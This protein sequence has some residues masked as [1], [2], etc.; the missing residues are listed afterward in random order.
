MFALNSEV[1]YGEITLC[2]EDA[3]I[4]ISLLNVIFKKLSALK[5]L[6]GIQFASNT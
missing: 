2:L 5:E 3:A 1:A 6:S 4:L